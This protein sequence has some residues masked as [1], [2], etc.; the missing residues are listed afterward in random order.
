MD[1]RAAI[2]QS[3]EIADMVANSYLSDLD[4]A[5]LLVR[6]VEGANHAAWQLGHL[7]SSENQLI[8]SLRPGSM[9]DLPEGFSDKHNKETAK[10]DDPAQFLKKDEYL[11]LLAQQREATIKVLEQMSDENFE[12]PSPEMFREHFPSHH[13]FCRLQLTCA[14]LLLLVC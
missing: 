11:Q 13:L 3:M 14:L 2:R 9:P 12:E 7:I 1:S 5:D 10:V 6:P 8:N 4:D